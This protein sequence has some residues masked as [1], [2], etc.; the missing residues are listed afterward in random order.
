MSST[1]PA[2]R[3]RAGILRE[4]RTQRV[5]LNASNVHK[6]ADPG[7]HLTRGMQV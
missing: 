3:R 1:I 4:N 5:L 6:S 7:A 2:P